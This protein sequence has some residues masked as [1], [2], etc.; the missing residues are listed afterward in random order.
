MVTTRPARRFLPWVTRAE[1]TEHVDEDTGIHAEAARTLSTILDEVRRGN[2]DVAEV[3][4]VIAPI[5]PIAADLVKAI[6]DRR[7]RLKLGAIA[8]SLAKGVGWCAGLVAAAYAVAAV[9][10]EFAT[11]LKHVF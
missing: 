5:E 8:V 3:R 7:F 4:R 2:Q 10:P 9:S 6:D 1:L 11:W